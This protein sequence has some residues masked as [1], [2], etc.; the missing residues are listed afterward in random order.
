MPTKEVERDHGWCHEPHHVSC[1]ILF[2][3]TYLTGPHT[4]RLR[5]ISG[6]PTVY[7]GEVS[8]DIVMTTN[9]RQAEPSKERAF[10]H[11]RT[12][13]IISPAHVSTHPSIQTGTLD[14]CLSWIM[15]SGF[16]GNLTPPER[17]VVRLSH[18]GYLLEII[19]RLGGL[20]VSRQIAILEYL[21]FHFLPQ[22]PFIMHLLGPLLHWFFE[23]KL[24]WRHLTY[25]AISGL[26]AL[27]SCRAYRTRKGRNPWKAFVF[28]CMLRQHWVKML[29]NLGAC[30]WREK[31]EKKKKQKEEREKKTPPRNKD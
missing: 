19:H 27:S 3:T 21:P 2:T 17:L 16:Q 7:H 23:Q 1:N 14:P 13:S 12:C 9:Y 20:L 28:R 24:T 30:L 15:A 6:S 31:D 22:G 26:L 18:A 5:E 4:T 11:N 29:Q 25:M 10:S 8:M